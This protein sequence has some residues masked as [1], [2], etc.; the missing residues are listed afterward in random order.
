MMLLTAA[1][2]VPTVALAAAIAL[3][4]AAIVV[5]WVRRR[6]RGE[7]GCG[8]SCPGCPHRAQCHKSP[9]KKN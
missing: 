7:S 9:E 6:K 2:H 4:F 1:I 3:I 5:R 8:C